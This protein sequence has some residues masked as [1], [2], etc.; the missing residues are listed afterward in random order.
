MAAEQELNSFVIK[1][2]Q[3]WKSGLTA[4]L[5]MDTSGGEAWVGIRVNLG[6]CLSPR[7]GPSPC[8]ERNS[9]SSKERRRARREFSRQNV[10]EVAE[11]VKEPVE[12]IKDENS[13]VTNP[14]EKVDMKN[15]VTNKSMENVTEK[16]KSPVPLVGVNDENEE[17]PK[18]DIETNAV[19]S[20]EVFTEKV[21]NKV[22]DI[23]IENAKD[24]M[25][26]HKESLG[27]FGC[28]RGLK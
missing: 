11:N 21:V 5:D 24:V 16:V 1:F 28:F 2:K 18:N 23:C 10:I 6:G 15:V 14:T 22:A 25:D 17:I 4:H 19:A 9:G 3:L 8:H 12:N 13:E 27:L 20:E 26:K 7:P